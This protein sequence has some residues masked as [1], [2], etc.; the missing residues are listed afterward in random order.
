LNKGTEPSQVDSE[1]FDALERGPYVDGFN[2]R[3]VVGALFVAFIMMPGAIYMGLVAGQSLGAAAEWVTIILFAELARRSF[4]RL[5][6]QEVYILFYVAS[7][8]AAVTVAHLAL[9]GGPFACT[10]WNQYLKQA[11]ETSTIAAEIPDWVVPPLDSP[12]LQDRNLSHIDW[13]WSTVL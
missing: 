13:W 8:I 3:T 9:S 4:T 5:K 7:G 12:A 2:M 10:I 1:D 11:P 6:R